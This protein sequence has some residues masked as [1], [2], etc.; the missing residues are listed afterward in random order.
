MANISVEVRS[1][2]VRFTAAVQAHIVQQ[3]LD[4]VA[5]RF[6]GSVVR[7]KSPIEQEDFW[8]RILPPEWD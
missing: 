8:S 6:P 3:A 4:I 5:T 7:A 2:T 1:E